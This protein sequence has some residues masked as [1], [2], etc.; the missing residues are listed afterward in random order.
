MAAKVSIVSTS[1]SRATPTR[2]SEPAANRDGS[3]PLTTSNSFS[4]AMGAASQPGD[5]AA[6]AASSEARPAAPNPAPAR[7]DSSQSPAAAADASKNPV[8]TSTG[9]S[10]IEGEL[11]ALESKVQDKTGDK[12]RSE[13][14][15]SSASAPLDASSLALLLAGTGLQI[16]GS[17]SSGSQS[18]QADD[19]RARSDAD[20]AAVTAAAGAVAVSL[21]IAASVAASM[22]AS[23]TGVTTSNAKST[24]TNP[25]G[26]ATVG[27]GSAR[28]DETPLIKFDSLGVG[29][30]SNDNSGSTATIQFSKMTTTDGQ[31]DQSGTPMAGSSLPD[32]VRSL[33]SA[34]A[35]SA[36]IERTI[37]VP[38]NDRNW[39]GAIAGQVQWLV[40]NNVQSATLQLSPEHLGPVEV[41]IDVQQS[42]VN[43]SFSAAHPDTRS[44]LEQSVPRL[45]EIFAGGGLTLGQATVQQ[46]ARP[47]SHFSPPASHT[48]LSG[49]QNA[50]SVAI[51]TTRALGLVDEYA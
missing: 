12:S 47:G 21:S 40:N 51:P 38:V 24:D 4:S 29:T 28:G 31:S 5:A 39:P 14:T 7:T 42:Q 16:D 37:A 45:R 11:S 27:V 23:A 25:V 44:A 17:N 33:A 19:T 2:S 9:A 8:T 46:E 35:Q 1:A 15:D 48:A 26:S 34:S 32:M 36:S 43:V 41:R 6:R 30:T 49:S 13:E 10:L 20:T 50:D 18:S 3:N 22:G